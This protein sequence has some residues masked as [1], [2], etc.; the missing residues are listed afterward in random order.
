[1]ISIYLNSHNVFDIRIDSLHT[2]KDMETAIFIV[3]E[4]R[5]YFSKGDSILAKIE[6]FFSRLPYTHFN[7]LI[8]TPFPTSDWELE[9]RFKTDPCINT[10]I[11]NIDDNDSDREFEMKL[12]YH[13]MIEKYKK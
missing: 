11:P 7:Y 2:F 10:N 6:E 3:K 5:K 1:M 8:I 9:G 13:L 4:F 12:L